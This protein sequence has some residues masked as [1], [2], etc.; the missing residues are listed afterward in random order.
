MN[1]LHPKLNMCEKT[2]TSRVGFAIALDYGQ[3]L[4]LFSLDIYDT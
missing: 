1:K 4:P 2:L 3:F